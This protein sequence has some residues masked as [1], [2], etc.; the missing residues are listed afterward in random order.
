MAYPTDTSKGTIS[1]SPGRGRGT[2]EPDESKVWGDPEATPGKL[3][4]KSPA[5]VAKHAYELWRSQDSAMN[6]RIAQWQV[7]A[8]QRQNVAE[9]RVIKEQDRYIAWIPDYVN[10]DPGRNPSMNKAATLDRKLVNQLLADPP[11]PEAVPASGE[12]VDAQAAEWSTRV[13]QDIQ[14]ESGLFEPGTIR[15]ACDRAITHSS[16][17]VLYWV[18]P[19]GGG[20]EP[21]EVQAGV[22]YGADGSVVREADHYDIAL[23]DPLTGL[24]WPAYEQRFVRRDGSLTKDRRE[25]ATQWVPTVK[26][27]VLTG[28]NVRFIPHTAED[29][30]D[31]RGLQIGSYSRTWGELKEMWPGLSDLTEEEIHK[32]LKFRP[33]HYKAILPD[34]VKLQGDG[35]VDEKNRDEQP[36]FCLTTYYAACDKYPDGI[37]VVTLAD[38][39]MAHRETWVLEDKES[40]EPL[41]IPVT[42]Y[43]LF[44][45]GTT[46]PYGFAFQQIV[47][48]G[49]EVRAA[50]IASVFDHLDEL[51]NLKTFIPT[52][53]NL[54]GRDM[55]STQK[56]LNVIPG[57]EPKKEQMPDFPA[58]AME[59]YRLVDEEMADAAGLGM[60][61]ESVPEATSGRHLYGQISQAHAG[62]SEPRMHI[63]RGYIRGCRITLQLIRAFFGRERQL[64]WLGEDNRYK[65]GAWKASDLRT[66]KDV[67]LAAGSLT[68]LTPA[69][70]AQF[71]E[72][73]NEKGILSPGDLRDT[74]AKNL[75]GTVVLQDDP[76]RS[77]IRSQLAEWAE[78]PPPL[79]ADQLEAGQDMAPETIPPQALK[80][81]EPVLADTLPQVAAI[82]LEELARFMSTKRFTKHSPVWRGLV[83]A[84][85]QRMNQ[86][87]NPPPAPP[88]P[89]PAPA[90]MP[91]GMPPADAG[92]MMPAAPVEFGITPPDQMPPEVMANLPAELQ[93][94]VPTAELPV[95]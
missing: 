80:I 35:A 32:I 2:E 51:G 47:G 74:L 76:Y 89:P 15:R 40:W 84:E 30:W 53:S 91:A 14:G 73:L 29:L 23:D 48:P 26:N 19:R 21:I 87:V 18:D 88:A 63:E 78:G 20:R 95:M 86:V 22:E 90:G 93:A 65:Y 60:L 34:G 39:Y 45:E 94:T 8:Y 82:R 37:Y 58:A 36:V 70:K 44:E 9:A 7:N 67:R 57:G 61:A 27:E 59:L 12:D 75:G 46:D 31:A 85:F 42:Q 13:L 55:T 92:P 81:W 5:V 25:A 33:K 83:E 10:E 77:R 41:E 64:K 69:Q 50:Q 1:Y 28:V 68:L 79:P 71:A 62:L 43:K 54:S 6:Q 52:T 56:Y 49:Q 17:F 4:D 66:T 16:G 3:L 72:H 11:A 24:P 38:C